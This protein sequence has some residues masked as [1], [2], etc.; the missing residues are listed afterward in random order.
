MMMLSLWECRSRRKG[1]GQ[2]AK[3]YVA[4]NLTRPFA[5]K[6][7]DVQAQENERRLFTAG[8]D[9]GVST[10]IVIPP[11]VYGQS[12]TFGN[13]LSIQIVGLCKAMLKYGKAIVI[14]GTDDLPQE[15]AICHVEDIAAMY[16]ALIKR[17]VRG[18]PAD[19]GLYF[20]ENGVIE[21]SKLSSKFAEGLNLPVEVTE[22]TPEMMKELV[23]VLGVQD[24][25]W[26]RPWIGGR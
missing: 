17:V 9:S 1:N 20:A 21:W 18:R 13:P 5:G 25:T 2:S 14:P 10:H 11:I 15:Y 6:R 16:I 23:G 22:A 7:P 24:E 3:W 19:S 8:K 12:R 4:I 26:V